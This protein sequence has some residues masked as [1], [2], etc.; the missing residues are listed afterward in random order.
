MEW[1]MEEAMY[2]QSHL[3]LKH[4]LSSHR[5]EQV[6]FLPWLTLSYRSS[7]E[8]YCSLAF[9]SWARIQISHPTVNIPPSHRLLCYLFRQC[10]VF[11][12]AYSFIIAHKEPLYL[13][14]TSFNRKWPRRAP[15]TIRITRTA[16]VGRWKIKE[17]HFQAHCFALCHR[18]DAA[19][20]TKTSWKEGRKHVCMHVQVHISKYT[21]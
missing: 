7:R 8:R 13:K 9:Y 15:V 17:E 2:V 21:Y 10:I 11:L 14:N 12:C 1:N 4:S 18:E 20:H 3:H 6:L 19:R 16:I 5:T